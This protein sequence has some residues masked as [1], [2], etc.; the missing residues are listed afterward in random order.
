MTSTHTAEIPLPLL[1]PAA[2]K[3]HLFPRLASGSLLS[4][5]QLCDFGC[6]AFFDATTMRVML[7]GTLICS[8]TRSDSTQRLWQ[9][10]TIAPVS[11]ITPSSSPSVNLKSTKPIIR[12]TASLKLNP[13]FEPKS[14][15]IDVS[16]F[17]N[18]ANAA[19]AMIPTA[20]S[21]ARV[22]FMNASLFSPCAS[23]LIKAIEAGRLTGFPWLTVELVRRHLPQSEATVRG[24]LDQQRKNLNSTQPKIP[25]KVPTEKPMSL[26]SSPTGESGEYDDL[27]PEPDEAFP[28]K[29]HHVFVA[30]ADVT[31]KVFSDQTG[32]FKLHSCRDHEE[33]VR[34]RNLGCLQARS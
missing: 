4:I 14:G 9:V 18:A 28:L 19:N 2:R 32:K 3:V 31:G 34:A 30:C 22:A 20:T 10:D 25:C 29:S 11:T 27:N 15:P 12:S 26:P 1:P 8:G 21:Q 23:T 5:G 24:H 33:Q 6:E 16:V 7:D 13:P 17:T